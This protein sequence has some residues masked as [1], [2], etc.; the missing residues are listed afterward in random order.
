MKLIIRILGKT[1]VYSLLIFVVLISVFPVLWVMLSS[2]KTNAEI[3]SGPFVLPSS[4]NLSAYE[5]LFYRYDFMSFFSNSFIVAGVSTLLGLAVFAAAAYVIARFSFPGKNLIF[6]LFIITLLVP[7]HARVQPIFSLILNWGLYDTLTG[8]TMVYL[9]AGM[10]VSIFI[11]KN[12]FMGIPKEVSEAATVDGAGFIRVFW[13]VC[14]PMARNGLVTAGILMFLSSWNEFYYA[15]L[16]TSSPSKRTLPVLTTLFN[17]QFS[18]DYT[19]TFAALTLL[20]IP[21]IVIYALAQ[22]QVQKSL[23]SGAVKG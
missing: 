6:S 17:T 19:K 7:G 3:L 12:T 15:S 1:G 8:L 16:L 20:I 13:S 10:A 2:I 22:E 5:Y 9:S 23:A 14:L 21:G 11:L 4:L 18:Y